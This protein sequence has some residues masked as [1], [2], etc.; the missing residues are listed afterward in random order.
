MTQL[1][2]YTHKLSNGQSFNFFNPS[3][4]KLSQAAHF[5]K[6]VDPS[7]QELLLSPSN[8]TALQYSSESKKIFLGMSTRNPFSTDR[9]PV[10]IDVK[11]IYYSILIGG[12]IGSGKSTLVT[13]LITGC[14]QQGL[15]VVIGEAKGEKA[16]D[17][18][19]AAF[20][21]LSLY[22]SQY[23][24]APLYRWPRGNCTFNPLLILNSLSE[25]KTFMFSL[26]TQIKSQGER[27][28]YVKQAAEISAYII[29]FLS[30]D[31]QTKNKCCTLRN[32]IRFLKSPKLLKKLL[33]TTK[34]NTKYLVSIRNELERLNFFV[35][36]EAKGRNHFMMTAGG[37]NDFINILE[38]EDLLF[39]TENHDTDAEGNSLVKLNLDDIIFDS[40]IV[41]ISQPITDRHPSAKII[42][43]L[44]WD[45]LLNRTTSLGIPPIYN[46][47]KERRGIAA[48][49]DETHRLP[50]GAMGESGDCLRQFEIGVIEILPT[51]GDRDRW[52]RN[53]HV[54]QTIISTS[55]GVPE[56]TELIANRLTPR[57][58]DLG[59]PSIT[60]VTSD[61]RVTIGFPSANDPIPVI[62]GILRKSGRFTALL[63][64]DLITDEFREADGLFWLDLD[65]PLMKNLNALLE[66][67]LAGDRTAEKLVNYALGL[68]TEFP[69]LKS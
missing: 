27:E 21:H 12:S 60:G 53:K 13:R 67:A 31:F 64:S 14:I 48:F 45:S 16:I 49:L 1:K 3:L 20:R 38:E 2:C 50:T 37:I 68:V 39:Y 59:E 8:F 19:R 54:Y 6:K 11:D 51:I 9:V 26:L 57:C 32:L 17:P 33:S 66:D 52:D 36:A 10:W 62:P 25:R 42:G 23:F 15:T 22:L 65:S 28:A 69:S 18:K 24:D 61:R 7:L 63:Y 44:F 47:G 30:V 58:L 29:D 55:P 46:N 41:V 43:T 40:S 34:N 5:P 4:C 56:V 35:L